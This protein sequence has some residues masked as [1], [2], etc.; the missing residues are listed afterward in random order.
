MYNFDKHLNSRIWSNSC[1]HMIVEWFQ[2]LPTEGDWNDNDV[3]IDG[4]LFSI[5][6]N[7]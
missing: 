3:P 5:K 1:E 2:G 7:L 6:K 4:I